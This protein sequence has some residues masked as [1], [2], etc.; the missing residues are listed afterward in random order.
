MT[1]YLHEDGYTDWGVVGCTQ[2]RRVAAVSVAK[3]VAD[4]MSVTVGEEV[5]YAIRFEDI[6]GPKT[7]IKYMTD[8]VL[9]RETLREGDLDGYSAVIMDEAHERS[10]NTDVLFGILKKVSQLVM[11][12]SILPWRV[13]CMMLASL[14]KSSSSLLYLVMCCAHLR[15]CLKMAAAMLT[16][17][18]HSLPALMSIHSSLPGEPQH[19]Q[20]LHTQICSISVAYGKSALACNCI[21]LSSRCLWTLAGNYACLAA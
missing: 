18:P 12:T 6:T 15:R 2:P 20:D 7:I 13:L 14:D 8:G 3:R 16:N 17:V 9:L 19:P 4:E 10:L 21:T 11:C 5:G 1:Q